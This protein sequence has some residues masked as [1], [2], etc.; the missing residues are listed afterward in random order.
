MAGQS[1]PF[2]VARPVPVRRASSLMGMTQASLP[3]WLMSAQ[4]IEL[5]AGRWER[6]PLYR[7]AG[8]LEQTD[9][10]QPGSLTTLQ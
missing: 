7:L 9:E 6:A 10:P 2:R 1:E 4:S 8:Y 5:G 3:E